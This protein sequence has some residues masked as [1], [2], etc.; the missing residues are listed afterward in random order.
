MEIKDVK[1]EDWDNNNVAD[2]VLWLD[3]TMADIRDYAVKGI[4]ADSIDVKNQY[5]NFIHEYVRGIADGNRFNR[6]KPEMI[7]N[8]K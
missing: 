5:L 3:L 6:K 2:P 1:R 7:I 4:Q 8:P